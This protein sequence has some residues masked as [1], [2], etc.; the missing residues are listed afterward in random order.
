MKRCRGGRIRNGRL[1]NP[2]LYQASEARRDCPWHFPGRAAFGVYLVALAALTASCA[3]TP[4]AAPRDPADAVPGVWPVADGPRPI[5]SVFGNRKDP[6]RF[7]S[8]TRFHSGVDIAAPKGTPVLAAG[9]GRV[10]FAGRDSAFG[11]IVRIDHGNGYVTMYAH[12][13][14][15]DAKQGKRVLRGERIGTVGKS[16]R[17]TGPHL[18]YEVRRDGKRVDPKT[19]LP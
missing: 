14:G 16:G 15:I 9:D 7:R 8:K 2:G 17:A 3:H 5:T 18:H 12:L 6:R 11:R 4:P 19:Y 1:E 13:S 10:A